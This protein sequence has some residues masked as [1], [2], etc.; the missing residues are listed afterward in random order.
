MGWIYLGVALLSAA[1]L[2]FEVTL[3]RLFSVTQWYHFAFLAVSVALL[4]YGASGTALSLVPRWV[5][6][7]TARRA[8]VFATLF[9][10]SVLGAY[11]GLNHL[12]FDSYRI[13]WE[14]SQLLY[15]LLY[16]LALTAPFFFSGLVTGMLLAAHPGHAARLYA[17]NLLGSAV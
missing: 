10:L 3:T 15:L 8:S 1:A 2:A 6:L 12:P 16:Y 7:P 17:A 13:A 11:L 14:R 9:A 5:K 4:G